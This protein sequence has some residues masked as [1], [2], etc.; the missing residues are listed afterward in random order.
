MY[1]K[2]LILNLLIFT[3]G[4]S[5]GLFININTIETEKITNAIEISPKTSQLTN[6]LLEKE[7]SK[8]SS[9]VIKKVAI[10]SK[11]IKKEQSANKT[12]QIPNQLKYF[13]ILLIQKQY[14]KALKLYENANNDDIENFKKELF[15]YIKTHLF[16]TI[17]IDKLLTLYLEYDYGNS[18]ILFYRAQRDYYQ[19]N[20][21]KAISDLYLIKESIYEENFKLK[22][23]KTL[24][25]YIT[26]YQTHLR[27]K[28]SQEDY[29][30]F[31][32][33]ILDKEPQNTTFLYDLATYYFEAS[34]YEK[35]K[36]LFENLENDLTY[37]KS[38][39]NFLNKIEKQLRLSNKYQ[40]KIHLEKLQ[41]HFYINVNINQTE[42]RLLIDTGA[43][44]TLVDKKI[45]HSTKEGKTIELH[46]A[47]GIKK[48]T[49]ISVESFNVAEISIE[50]F[51]ITLSDFEA[52][53]FDG[54]LGMNFLGQFDFYIDQEAAILYLN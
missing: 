34:E 28:G 53:G 37:S 4:F 30:K 1:K 47:N 40:Q 17:E 45:L 6:I 18:T 38:A 19:K 33:Y 22:V 16:N 41:N 44:Y 27:A 9:A 35:A 12:V 39:K 20:Y 24:T 8:P 25:R 48:A 7:L 21:F 13:K 29:Y 15:G 51:E 43:S 14:K 32:Y 36:E 42:L 26:N 31:L 3:I 46:T 23:I 11:N 2:P 10:Q 49:I 52:Q 5:L 54:L 50:D